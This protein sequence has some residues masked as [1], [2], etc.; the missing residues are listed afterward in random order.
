MSLEKQTRK[1][2]TGSGRTIF[3]DGKFDKEMKEKGLE[4]VNALSDKYLNNLK[5]E[6]RVVSAISVVETEEG[7]VASQMII[8][9][10]IKHYSPSN[11]MNAVERLLC[12]GDKYG[13]D[14]LR[15][16]EKAQVLCEY[17]LDVMRFMYE[18]QDRKEKIDVNDLGNFMKRKVTEKLAELVTPDLFV[19]LVKGL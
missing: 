10:K 3:D 7:C 12:D 19:D 16:S 5:K 9:K 4:K 11:I 13:V 14:N 6:D 1:V 2:T 18:H 8:P 17:S 15:G